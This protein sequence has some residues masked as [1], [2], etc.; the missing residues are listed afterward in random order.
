MKPNVV[1]QAHRWLVRSDPAFSETTLYKFFFVAYFWHFGHTNPKR[2]LE[3]IVLMEKESQV[4]FY[5]VLFL[6]KKFYP[7]I[8]YHNPAVQQKLLV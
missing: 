8:V 2:V 6:R 1:K 7:T 3:D 5:M 4:P